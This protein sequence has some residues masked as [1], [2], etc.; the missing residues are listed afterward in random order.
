MWAG[1]W[2]RRDHTVAGK[3][4]AANQKLDQL[5]REQLRHEQAVRDVRTAQLKWNDLQGEV[6][7]MAETTL[8][9]MG[10]FCDRMD[11][12][13]HQVDSLRHQLNRIERQLGFTDMTVQAFI[14]AAQERR[15]E[16]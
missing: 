13:A 16:R 1:V 2:F 11:D 14:R 9:L 3:L 10:A 12:F 4:D 5:T 8:G 7:M 6:M 15:S